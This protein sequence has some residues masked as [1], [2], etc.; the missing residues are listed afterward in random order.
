MDPASLETITGSPSAML[1]RKKILAKDLATTALIPSFSRFCGAASRLEPQPKLSPATMI[2]PSRTSGANLGWLTR[3]C[4]LASLH[5]IFQVY[6]GDIRSVFTL[7]PNSHTRLF[8]CS[9]I[10][11]PLLDPQFSHKQ[12]LPP[13]PPEIRDRCSPSGCPFCP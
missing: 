12:Q 1:F 8:S 10:R 7:S 5:S 2:S 3:I 13:P 6:P 9:F 11:T 4:F